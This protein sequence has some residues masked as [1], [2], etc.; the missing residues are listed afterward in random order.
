MS[1][2]HVFNTPSECIFSILDFPLCQ[3]VPDDLQSTDFSE[4]LL[5]VNRSL[6]VEL[7]TEQ[8]KNLQLTESYRQMKSELDDLKMNSTK[9]LSMTKDDNETTSWVLPADRN[10][11]FTNSVSSLKSNR[12]IKE[13]H[14]IE[15]NNYLQ[16]ELSVCKK[17]M[18]AMNSRMVGFVESIIF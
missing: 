16:S 8:M 13:E 10:D 17:E 15:L 1:N 11:I 5:N 14:L 6:L 2:L 12:S 4:A 9:N 3:S 7:Q 18:Y